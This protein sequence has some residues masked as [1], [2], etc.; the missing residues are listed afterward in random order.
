MYFYEVKRYFIKGSSMSVMDIVRNWS[1]N[2]KSKSETFQKMQEQDKLDNMLEER[3]KS[4]NL[5]ELEKFYKDKEEDEIKKRL[6]VIHKQQNKDNWK[7]NSIL[8][9]G[10]SILKDDRPILKE[11]N[12]FKGEKNMFIDKKNKVPLQNKREGMFFKW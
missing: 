1:E 2:R 7:S 10:K 11:K 5:R 9:K 3:K 12:I 8:T 4:A 6:D